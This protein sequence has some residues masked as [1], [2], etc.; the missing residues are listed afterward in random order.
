MQ[1]QQFEKDFKKILKRFQN[2]FKSYDAKIL[3]ISKKMFFYICIGR[4]II[5]KG[6]HLYRTFRKQ[7]SS[8]VAAV[9][10]FL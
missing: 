9:V 8:F 1:I 2:I 6:I 5:S 7:V 3:I 4:S 10:V